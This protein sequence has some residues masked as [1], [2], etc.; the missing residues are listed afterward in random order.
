MW[1]YVGSPKNLGVVGWGVADGDHLPP[2]AR[3]AP[4]PTWVTMLNLIAVGQTM[5]TL[6]AEISR[7]KWRGE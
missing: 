4:L 5:R 1:A 3:N 7:K 2:P 6:R